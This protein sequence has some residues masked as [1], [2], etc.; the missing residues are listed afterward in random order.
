MTQKSA[1]KDTCQFTK[2]Y[3]GSCRGNL[4]GWLAHKMRDEEEIDEI[5]Y[6]ELW[7][8][9]SDDTDCYK[10][11]RKDFDFDFDGKFGSVDEIEHHVFRFVM[12]DGSC[13]M[14]HRSDGEYTQT[15]LEHVPPVHP[16]LSD[17]KN[18]LQ[19]RLRAK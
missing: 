2:G 17:L 10:C 9:R 12:K 19:D 7:K 4:L 18:G 1:L 14:V 13:Y 5:A 8:H 16:H 3:P 11:S 6:L 15:W